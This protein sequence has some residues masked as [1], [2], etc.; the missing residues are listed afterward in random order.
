MISKINYF[1]ARDTRLVLDNLSKVI[2]NKN[3]LFVNY[4]V[5]RRSLKDEKIIVARYMKNENRLIIYDKIK[6]YNSNVYEAFIEWAEE[7]EIE[8][9]NFGEE[10]I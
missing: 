8:W 2:I 9:Y 10:E 6:K 1:M 3:E 4:T 5:P 7:N